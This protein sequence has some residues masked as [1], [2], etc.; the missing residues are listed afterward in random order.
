VDGADSFAGEWDG[1]LRTDDTFVDPTTLAAP[2]GHF[3][4]RTG[5]LAAT[6]ARGRHDVI[7]ARRS[8]SPTTSGALDK[9]FTSFRSND[10]GDGT[11]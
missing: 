11:T 3:Y 7:R 9:L 5:G 8:S 2:A 1:A 10:P 6:S 4:Y